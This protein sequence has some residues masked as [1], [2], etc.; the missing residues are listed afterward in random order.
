MAIPLVISAIK[1]LIRYRDRV[2]TILSLN[3]AATGLPFR[4]PPAPDDRIAHLDSM[5]A[6]GQTRT[7]EIALELR[8][9]SDAYRRV[10]QAKEQGSQIPAQDALDCIALYFEAAAVEPTSFGPGGDGDLRARASSGPSEEMRLAYF[11]VESHR[12]SRNPA[13]T[14]VLLATA[15][16]LLEVA[17]ENAGFFVSNPRTRGIVESLLNEFAV[18]RDFDDDSAE[19]IFRRLLGAAAVAAIENREQLSDAPALQALFGALADVRTDLGDEFVARLVTRDGFERL[20]AGYATQVASDPSFLTKHELARSAISATLRELAQSF[21]RIAQGDPEAVFAVLEAGIAVAAAHVPA[22]LETELAGRPLSTAILR[23]LARSVETQAASNALFENVARGRIFGELYRVALS[24]VA[25]S[26]EEL[27]TE[28]GLPA[29]AAELAA[30]VASTLVQTPIRETFGTETFRELVA[31]S[32]QV[33]ARHPDAVVRDHQFGAKVISAVFA[34]A[35]PA[36]RDGLRKDD[37]LEVVDAALAAA[38]GNAALLGL[39]ERLE[40]VLEALGGALASEGLRGLLDRESRKQALLVAVRAVA[41]NPQV[42]GDFARSDQVQPI[43]LGIAEGLAS[44]PTKLLSGPVLVEAL[45][46]CLQATARRGGVIVA[47]HVGDGALRMLLSEALTAARAEVG[48]SIDGE[49]LPE[50]VERVLLGF[51]A[52]PF[53]LDGSHGPKL[54]AVF[55]AAVDAIDER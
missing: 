12:L 7:G 19:M 48:R 50:F 13:L 20:V 23:E 16:T 41:A 29:F 43:A 22:I 30:G 3:E 26:P 8:G 4:L 35:A 18:K 21:P 33:M 45:R 5:I 51:L 36:V 42:W 2:D 53:D 40:A 49:N 46:R 54:E 55:E 52:A 1:A 25:A 6:F 32:L 39:D 28:A 15:D 11:V 27:A 47:G 44:D 38:G 14:R 31:G 10:R 24:A 34:A 37:V 9:L 17:G